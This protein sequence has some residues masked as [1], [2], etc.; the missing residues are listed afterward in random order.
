MNPDASYPLRRSLEAV[1]A[2]LVA[3]SGA[4]LLFA[5][6]LLALG[7]SPLN[8]LEIVWNGA[9]GSWFSIQNTLQRAAPLLLQRFA[10]PSP[11]NSVL[12]S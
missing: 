9:F 2:P 8:F 12:L 10:L 1:L 7:Q 4:L 5:I 3:L 11:G 6:F